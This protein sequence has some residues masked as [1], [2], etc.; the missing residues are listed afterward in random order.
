MDVFALY[1][2]VQMNDILIG[3]GF[4]TTDLGSILLHSC[5]PW[6]DYLT[7]EPEFSV[8]VK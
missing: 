1:W 4:A 3:F 5:E 6:A 2:V 7:L 8:S